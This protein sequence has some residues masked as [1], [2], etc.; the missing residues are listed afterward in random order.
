MLKKRK[1]QNFNPA[2][3]KGGDKHETALGQAPALSSRDWSRWVKFVLENHTTQ[4]AVLIEFTGLFTAMRWGLCIEGLRSPSPGKSSTDADSEDKGCWK[5]PWQHTHH[6]GEG[7]NIFSNSNM[8]ESA[9]VARCKQTWLLDLPGQVHD[10][11][12]RA[13]VRQQKG[14]KEKEK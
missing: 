9:E 12:R 7:C 11:Q 3:K 13:C 2:A 1:V 4:M 8:K 6:K 10:F 14:N 5:K